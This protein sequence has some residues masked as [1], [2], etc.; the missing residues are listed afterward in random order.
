MEISKK[1]TSARQR[2]YDVTGW[3][4]CLPAVVFGLIFLI[5]PIALSFLFSFTDYHM[6]RGLNAFVG[7]KHYAELLK[8]SCIS[9]GD[10][11]K[12]YISGEKK[13][14]FCEWNGILKITFTV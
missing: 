5:T 11:S 10:F 6:L 8:D 4:F 12:T 3:L 14:T 13:V 9:Y 2:R 1:K 7:F